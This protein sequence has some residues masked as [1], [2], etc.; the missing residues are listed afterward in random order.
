MNERKSVDR[1]VEVVTWALDRIYN[2]EYQE[3]RDSQGNLLSLELSEKP[4]ETEELELFFKKFL[5]PEESEAILS[6]KQQR[7][8]E[9]IERVLRVVFPSQVAARGAEDLDGADWPE[10]A[11]YVDEQLKFLRFYIGRSIDEFL[12]KEREGLSTPSCRDAESVLEAKTSEG[13]GAACADKYLKEF[14][15]MFP[16]M[17]KRANELRMVP[18]SKNAPESVSIYLVEATR[19]Y[20]YGH[21]LACLIVCRSAVEE[22]V[23][24]RLVAT[25]KRQ[26]V[27]GSKSLETLLK[28]AENAGLLV[29]R[30]LEY[31]NTIRKKAGKA[32][33]GREI[34]TDSECVDALK[35]TR[36][37]LEQLYGRLQ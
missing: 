37:I 11:Q 21:F 20:I 5:R 33:H 12:V 22:A 35:K 2:L 18:A 32:V 34:P 25:G 15:D 6:L 10:I 3:E 17:V 30:R 9:D 14:R 1:V 13:L 8:P 31:A 27:E 26:E 28:L 16:E 36:G 24:Q 19:C 23:K 4:L 29:G 7:S